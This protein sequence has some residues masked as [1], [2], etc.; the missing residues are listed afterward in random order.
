MLHDF[1][2]VYV[3]QSASDPRLVK[4]GKTQQAVARRVQQINEHPEYGRLG[5]WVYVGGVYH[6]WHSSLE[7]QAHRYF[8]RKRV[9]IGRCSEIFRVKPDAAVAVVLWLSGQGAKPASG[10]FILFLACI[11]AGIFLAILFGV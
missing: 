7:L 3:L 4:I 10:R 11:L 9:Q 5:P 8:R 1:G 2:H 6:K